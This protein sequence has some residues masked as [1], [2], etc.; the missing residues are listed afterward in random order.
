MPNKPLAEKDVFV[1]DW[2][3]AAITI[4]ATPQML[5]QQSPYTA[6]EDKSLSSVIPCN[7]RQKEQQPMHAHA[8]L[9]QGICGVTK[10]KRTQSGYENII[11]VILKEVTT[12]GLK[13]L[14]KMH[15][16]VNF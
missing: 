9:L 16:C 6:L 14:I 13:T 5:L 12:K 15:L 4:S 1:E 8:G 2:A 7:T 11:R 3:P 10:Q